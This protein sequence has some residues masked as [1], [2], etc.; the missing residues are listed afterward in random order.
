MELVI[1]VKEAG[2]LDYV[3]HSLGAYDIDEVVEEINQAID[4]G[5][6]VVFVDASGESFRVNLDECVDI[7]VGYRAVVEGM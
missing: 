3:K 2:D 5:S 7:T 4:A 6:D 1:L